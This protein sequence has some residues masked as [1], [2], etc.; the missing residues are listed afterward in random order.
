MDKREALLILNLIP[1]VGPVRVRKLLERFESPELILSAPV[2][3]LKEV[4]GIGTE[5]AQ[6]ISDWEKHVDRDAELRAV[7]KAGAQLLIED[8]EDYP[9]NL[10]EIYDPPLVLYVRGKLLPRDNKGIAVVGSRETSNYGLEAAKKLSYQMAFSGVTVVS[11]LA[12]GIDTAAH[13]GALAAKGRTVAVIGAGLNQIYPPENQALADKII[14]AGAAIISEFPM[15]AKPTPQNFPM[16]NRIVSGMSMG[17]LVVEADLRSGA[18]ITARMALD[19]GKLLFAVPGRIDSLRSRGCHRLI[20]QGAKLVEDVADI[21]GEFEFLF[22]AGGIPGDEGE[23]RRTLA[24]TE[25]SDN[26]QKLFDLLGSEELDIDTLIEQ[27][28]LPSPAVSASLL[29]LETPDQTTPRQTFCPRGVKTFDFNPPPR[30]RSCAERRGKRKMVRAPFAK[31]R[32]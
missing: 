1:Q 3:H 23:S 32:D 10:R 14:E 15:N 25:L 5:V 9:G 6:N 19:Q 4:S 31:D 28:N 12:R 2:R 26:E 24:A 27:S 21:L 29:A 30:L 7:E 20:K 16:R 13:Q 17:T 11:G 8:D 18:L 22:P